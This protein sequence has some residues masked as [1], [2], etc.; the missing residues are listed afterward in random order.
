MNNNNIVETLDKITHKLENILHELE[1]DHMKKPTAGLTL[2]FGSSKKPKSRRK[3]STQKDDIERHFNLEGHKANNMTSAYYGIKD[4]RVREL[5]GERIDD[6]HKRMN[7]LEK[8]WRG[9]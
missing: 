9:L 3:R 5:V 2:G 6:K 8:K 4:S 1:M 7:E